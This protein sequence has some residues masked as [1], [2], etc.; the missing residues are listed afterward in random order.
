MSGI[1]E[2]NVRDIAHI[3]DVLAATAERIEAIGELVSQ[4]ALRLED[5]RELVS[6]TALRLEGTRDLVT[7]NAD[8]F[9]LMLE[10]NRADR[11]EWRGRLERLEQAA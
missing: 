3:E 8:L 5:T 9:R 2:R 7:Q 6:Q 10:E 1:A 4:T 11:S